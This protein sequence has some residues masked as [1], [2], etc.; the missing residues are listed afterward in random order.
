MPELTFTNL[1]V[2]ATTTKPLQSSEMEEVATALRNA[3]DNRTPIEAPSKT[4]PGLDRDT[5][6]R[7]MER[8]CQHA[9]RE[10]GDRLVGYKLGNIAKGEKVPLCGSPQV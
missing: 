1:R 2:P 3:K 5:A 9:V 7:V 10:R 6:F 8:G 4:W